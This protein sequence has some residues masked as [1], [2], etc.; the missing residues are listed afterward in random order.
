MKKWKIILVDDDES[1]H[2]AAKLQFKRQKI[3]GK[4]VEIISAYSEFEAMDLIRKHTDT[5][6]MIVD[7]IMEEDYSGL[8]L[9]ERVRNEAKNKKVRIIVRSGYVDIV[10]KN[11]RD[12]MKDKYDISSFRDKV[13]IKDDFIKNVIKEVRRFKVYSK[14]GFIF[15]LFVLKF[16]ADLLKKYFD[17]K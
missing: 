4:S 15:K 5:C 14:I 16:M 11:I 1:A 8:K 10:S 9:I 7:I 17:L 2:I 3:S 12:Q 6:L 13:D